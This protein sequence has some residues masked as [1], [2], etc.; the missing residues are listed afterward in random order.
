[1][2]LKPLSD[3]IACSN[4]LVFNI[5]NE[6]FT[7]FAILFLSLRNKSTK[8]MKKI[9]YGISSF[10]TIQTENYYFVD[11]T[12]YIEQ[13]E[14]FGGRYLFFLRPRRFGKSLLVSMLEHYYDINGADQ[15]DQLFGDTYIGQNPTPLRNSYPV[16]RF[17]FSMIKTQGTIEDLKHGFCLNVR[18]ELSAFILKY[19]S[20]YNL[21]EE[22]LK[23]IESQ[24]DPGDMLLVFQGE[25]RAKNLS[26]YMIIDEYD[27]FA[28]NILIGHGKKIY[29]EITHS[30]GFLRNFFTL[31]KGFTDGRE[32]D[33][34]FISGVSPLVMADVTSGFNI[35]DNISLWSDFSAMAGFTKEEVKGLIDYYIP[36]RFESLFPLISEW[37]NNYCFGNK[38]KEDNIFNSTS[39]LYF[40][41]E[42][43]R[44]DA[45]PD[46]LIDVNLRTDYGKL[47]FLILEEKKLN[48][49]F[50]I[51]NDL[52]QTK[53]TTG[54]LVRSF[55][56]NELINAEKFRSLLFYLGF[57]TLKEISP[58]GRYTFTIPN[59][60]INN[61]LWEY[62][63]KSLN[64]VYELKIDNDLLE[65]I[66]TDMALNGTWKP[67]LQYIIDKFY[68]AVSIRDFT[69]HEEG[70]KTFLLAWLNLTNLYD[71]ISEKEKNKGYADICLETDRR[72]TEYVKYEYIIE[73]KYIKAEEIETPDKENVAISLAVKAATSQLMQYA[74][75][76]KFKTIKIIILASAKKLLL[77]DCL[78]LDSRF[79]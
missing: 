67:A 57:T 34:L 47:R 15:F 70:L 66:F 65:Q 58:A 12:K 16:L 25:I 19:K 61:L 32:I 8:K 52:V 60:L 79:A 3:L 18:N 39:I 38:L 2:N 43:L 54:R 76:N 50:T 31:I 36:G 4:C 9:P 49:N 17:N 55:A 40:V 45:I 59:K 30:S 68:Q 6:F 21:D 23:K 42:Y 7:C 53:E 62:I 41:K 20:R 26:L 71:V 24:T 5:K 29:T 73:L 56:V 11:K 46:E 78:P 27:N 69:F 74:A 14:N 44:V 1:M 33:R 72:F 77:M 63:Q 10:E 51:L 28:N 13:I 22:V 37:Y 64:E 35:G 75:N 48:G